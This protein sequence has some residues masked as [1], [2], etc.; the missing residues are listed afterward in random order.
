MY[1]SM[2]DITVDVSGMKQ[3]P[4]PRIDGTGAKYYRVNYDVILLFG[5][6][7]LQAQVAWKEDV[8]PPYNS[9]FV[10]F[11][12]NMVLRNGTLAPQISFRR[13]MSSDMDNRTPAKIIYSPS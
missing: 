3:P 8:R 5:S 7:E 4:L 1:K 13:Y 6:T 9:L 12:D 10:I 2:C 11:T